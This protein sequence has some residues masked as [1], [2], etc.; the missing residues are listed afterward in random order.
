MSGNPFTL[1]FDKLPS[2]LPIFPLPHALVMAGCQL[3][4]NIFEPCYLNMVFDAFSGGRLI[5]MVQPDP[6]ASDGKRVAVYQTG[7]AGRISFLNE[8]TDGRLLILL[9]GVCRFDIHEEIP[10]TRGYRRVRADWSPYRCDYEDSSNIDGDR[11]KLLCLLGAYLANQQI[12]TELTIP[13][14]LDTTAL[15][16]RLICALPFTVEER[17]MLIEAVS[18]EERVVQLMALLEFAVSDAYANRFKRH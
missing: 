7:T 12:D 17:Q 6:S 4:L 8:T 15:M 2:S 13:D 9:N 5:G 14:L 10:T 1:P 16:N 11:E 18:P 3:P